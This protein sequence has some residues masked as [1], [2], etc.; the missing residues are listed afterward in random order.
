[1]QL[2]SMQPQTFEV[3]LLLDHTEVYQQ[4]S[5]LGLQDHRKLVL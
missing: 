1:M 2:V 5:V 4:I 3:V